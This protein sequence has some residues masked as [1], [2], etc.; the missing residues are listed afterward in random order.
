[1][2]APIILVVDDEPDN[3][4]VIDAF[5]DECGYQLHYVANGEQALTSLEITKPDLILLD[6]M[7]PVLDGFAVCQALKQM[8]RWRHVPIIMVTALAS[9]E[10]LARCLKAGADDF[11]GKPVNRLELQA[12]VR[13]MLRIKSQFDRI[14]WF[15]NS[16]RN[17]INMLGKNLT[18]LSQS[19]ARS[20][21]HEINTPL[22]G[23]VGTIE[24][25]QDEFEELSAGE[26]RELLGIL[27]EMAG[28]LESLLQK[29]LTYVELEL[30][31]SP[32]PALSRPPMTA[33]IDPARLVDR[34]NHQAGLRTPDLSINLQPA[35]IAL[36]PHYLDVLISELL[37]NALK[38][39]LPGTRISLTGIA[40]TQEWVLTITDQ[41]RGMTKQ[42]IAEIKPFQ[43]FDRQASDRPG[44][45]LGL[46]IAQKIV[47]L[48]K[49]RLVLDSEPGKATQVQ[50]SLPLS[51][52]QSPTP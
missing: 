30:I 46:K 31:T 5:L 52:T 51:P 7:M 2:V 4:D 9:K 45:G 27:A 49:G 29:F 39:S 12:R 8:P 38:F 14:Q 26:V 33:P 37:S 25:L 20:L 19:I 22:N 28:C 23:L 32:D 11:I 47:E 13:S 42:Q 50:V 44:I 18:Q 34:L 21:P 43:Q 17:T 10:D 35:T 15:S 6:V 48:G 36:S 24:I 41:G 3:F 16:Q 1:M 40:D